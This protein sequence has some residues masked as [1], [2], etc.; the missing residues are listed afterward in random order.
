M[1]AVCTLAPSRGTP[2]SALPSCASREHPSVA[3]LRAAAILSALRGNAKRRLLSALLYIFYR[4]LTLRRDPPACRT[5]LPRTALNHRFLRGKCLK[6]Y[7][8]AAIFARPVFSSICSLRY[9]SELMSYGASSNPCPWVI[10]SVGHASTQ[11]PQKMH[12]E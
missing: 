3:S 6:N 10:A 2:R 12:R 5:H 7:P 4:T 9:T 1:I 8:P 11:Y